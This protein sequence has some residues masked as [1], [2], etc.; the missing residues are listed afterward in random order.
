MVI[1]EKQ[2]P[3]WL[4]LEEGGA[5]RFWQS[6]PLSEKGRRFS[7][8]RQ[9]DNIWYRVF[10]GCSI[11]QVGSSPVIQRSKWETEKG[12]DIVLECLKETPCWVIAIV[13]IQ[14]HWHVT[15]Q[16]F[17]IGVTSYLQCVKAS[18]SFRWSTVLV[19]WSPFYA[20]EVFLFLFNPAFFQPYWT[21]I[22]G[23]AQTNG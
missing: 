5:W 4:C 16:K 15:V 14:F 8:Q 7:C 11:W 2:G 23:L 10:R 3:T 1:K 12:W 22:R 21:A 20:S 13:P 19:G 17:S 18:L 6:S 9:K